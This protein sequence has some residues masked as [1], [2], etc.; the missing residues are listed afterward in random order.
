MSGGEEI[1][2]GVSNVGQ[3]VGD[4]FTASALGDQEAAYKREATFYGE[5]AAVERSSTNIQ[6][7]QVQRQATQAIGGQQAAMAAS[8]FLQS[9]SSLDIIRDS[10][11]QANIARTVV[12]ENGLIKEQS[13]LAQQEAAT[14]AA[15]AAGRSKVGME[16][17]GGISIFNG[18]SQIADGVAQEVMS[19]GGG[20]GG[21]G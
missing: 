19:S 7:F 6:T 21:G 15:R 14:D 11:Q 13:D 18:I 9:G 1:G 4:L 3:G 12:A 2:Q 17:V 5:A 8:G 16:I 20:G 10:T